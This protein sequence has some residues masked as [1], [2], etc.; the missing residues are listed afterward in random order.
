LYNPLMRLKEFSFDLPRERIARF[1]SQKR[2]ESRLMVVERK[3]GRISH[4]F[5]KDIAALIGATDFLVV[6]NSAV[7]P[8]R[9]FGQINGKTVDILIVKPLAEK[10]AEVLALPARR[11]KP[12]Q[13]VV[14]TEDL[15]AEVVSVGQRGKR[16]LRFNQ[17]LDAVWQAG[18]APLP[19]YIKRT[20]AEAIT[21]KEMDL[22]RY[23]TVYSR[24]PGSIAAPT[25]GLHFSPRILEQIGEKTEI[26]EITLAVGE[27]T[28]QKIQ[29]EE[30]SE[31]QMGNETITITQAARERIL[32][33][34]QS[35]HL[36]AVGTTTVRSL[37]TFALRES[38]E[39]TFTSELFIFPGFAFRM[40]DKLVTNFHLPESSLFILVSAFAGLE[41]MQEAY[42][43]AVAE[44]YRFFSYGDAMFIT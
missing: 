6:N 27:A 25:A 28:F 21:F 43:V 7:I 35:K 33:L 11:F 19:P 13:E 16:I 5:F 39:E 34:K 41:L 8:A 44:G 17:D 26:I 31:H 2:D 29:A 40:V 22:E 23:Q 42:R 10:E 18:Y 32:R 20:Y 4:H 12:G 37:E 38:Q 24:R 1:P 9:L 3:T 36:V 30:I 15:W 14:F